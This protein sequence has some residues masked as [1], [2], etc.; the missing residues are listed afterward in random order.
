MPT[1]QF[2]GERR[3]STCPWLSPDFICFVTHLPL[4]FL[5]LVSVFPLPHLY[6]L[7]SPFKTLLAPKPS[8]QALFWGEPQPREK[9]I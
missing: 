3:Q 7:E 2:P 5:S 9:Y 1:T 8:F 4:A 6:F